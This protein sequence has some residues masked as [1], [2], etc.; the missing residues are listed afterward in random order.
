MIYP[1]IQL[2]EFQTKKDLLLNIID[3]MQ[4][5]EN[6]KFWKTSSLETGRDGS[7]TTHFANAEIQ[8][9]DYQLFIQNDTVK[10]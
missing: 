9:P 7:I 3:R 5:D 8:K 6:I 4:D 1:E 2:K 10:G